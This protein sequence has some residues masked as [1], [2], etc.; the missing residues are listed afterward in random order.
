MLALEFAAV[1]EM[2]RVV[3]VEMGLVKLVAGVFAVKLV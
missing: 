1:V 2:G 3:V